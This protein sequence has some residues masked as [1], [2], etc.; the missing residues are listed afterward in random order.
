MTST[1]LPAA[2]LTAVG[3]VVPQER[4]EGGATPQY[5]INDDAG[6]SIPY[7]LSFIKKKEARR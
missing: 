7:F 3:Q 5:A 1:L 4:N 2:R 6:S